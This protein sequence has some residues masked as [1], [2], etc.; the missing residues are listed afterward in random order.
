ML[1]YIL[2]RIVLMV[3]TL[4][5]MTLMLFIVVRFAPGLTTG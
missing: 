3:P 2:R 1:A 5:G 4:I